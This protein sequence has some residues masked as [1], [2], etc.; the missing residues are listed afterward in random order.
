LNDLTTGSGGINDSPIARYLS[1]KGETLKRVLRC[2]AD[3]VNAH[4]V[5]LVATEGPYY[6]SYGLNISVGENY[7]DDVYYR[8]RT[9]YAQWRSPS[10]KIMM[11]E[12]QV[13]LNGAWTGSGPLAVRH[14]QGTSGVT[15]LTIAVG[16]SA[17]FF[18]GHAAPIDQD[19]SNDPAHWAYPYP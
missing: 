16:T 18:D 1:L 4:R 10:S 2:P 13:P 14:G 15:G 5:G 9:K 17:V 19:Y 11:S 6:Y 12:C 8:Q 7:C 3:V